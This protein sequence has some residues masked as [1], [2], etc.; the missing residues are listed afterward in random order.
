VRRSADYFNG[1]SAGMIS[2]RGGAGGRWSGV[3]YLVR[4][5]LVVGVLAGLPWA[6]LANQNDDGADSGEAGTPASTPSPSPAHHHKRIHPTG[7]PTASPSPADEGTG[8][9]T[10][11]A[12]HKRV[13]GD[14]ES[15]ADVTPPATRRKHRFPADAEDSTDETAS[16]S[17]FIE[18]SDAED[19]DSATPR[20]RPSMAPDASLD[21]DQL[22]EFSRQPGNIRALI[23]ASLELTR[24]NLTYT[25]AS[26]DPANGGMDCS[27]FV[28][29]VLTQAG[30][31]DVPRDA[32][33]QYSW[34]RKAGNFRAVISRSVDGFEMDELEPGDLLFWIGTY[35]TDR[36]PPVTHTMI[37]LGREKETGNRVMVGSSDGRSYHGLQR[38]GVSVF[39]FKAI[40]VASPSAGRTPRFI[41]YGAIPGF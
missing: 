19:V 37:Y 32:S 11:G 36:D 12:S 35:N 13:S 20:P 25:P 17:P 23:E 6:L 3:R 39:D 41:G 22:Q 5:A 21:T 4:R 15:G 34:V 28:Y 1:L 9:A 24:Q 2:I 26:A 18:K 40:T 7:Y 16:P 33:E 38:W 29:Y 31:K 14:T 27:G 10:P 30:I 8:S